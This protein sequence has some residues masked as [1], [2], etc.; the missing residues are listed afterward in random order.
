MPRIVRESPGKG[1][2]GEIISVMTGRDGRILYKGPR[3]KTH[4]VCEQG[5]FSVPWFA[6]CEQK[7]KMVRFSFIVNAIAEIGLPEKAVEPLIRLSLMIWRLKPKH[8]FGL[9]RKIIAIISTRQKVRRRSCPIGRFKPI[10]LR[11]Q[12]IRSD[13]TVSGIIPLWDY[14]PV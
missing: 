12:E 7:R 6:V 4:P 13:A 2:D 10:L 8:C 1:K 5:K 14:V 9:M 3:R 11:G